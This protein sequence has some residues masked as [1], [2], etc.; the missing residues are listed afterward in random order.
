[1][2]GYVSCFG[3]LNPVPGEG[4]LFQITFEAIGGAGIIVDSRDSAV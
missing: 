3:E 4:D 1:M 2:R